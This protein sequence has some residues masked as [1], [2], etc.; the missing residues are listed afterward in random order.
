MNASE[1]PPI[2]NPLQSIQELLKLPLTPSEQLPQGPSDSD[3][4]MNLDQGTTEKD[5][6]ERFKSRL[7]D[8]DD[9]EWVCCISINK[10]LIKTVRLG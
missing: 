1:W 4:W 7:E 9:E 5:W 10:K 3:E 2:W 8:N 6:E